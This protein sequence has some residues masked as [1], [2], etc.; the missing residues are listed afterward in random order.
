MAGFEIARKFV[1]AHC[2]SI[3]D[4]GRFEP[5]PEALQAKHANFHMS[6]EV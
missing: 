1:D 6:F 4:T 3:P 2:M 5:K